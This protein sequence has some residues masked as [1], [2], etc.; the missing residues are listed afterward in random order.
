M[1]DLNLND[2]PK[3]DLMALLTTAYQYL[4]D[5]KKAEDQ[6]ATINRRIHQALQAPIGFQGVFR[7][8]VPV[9]AFV[10]TMVV[11]SSI[12]GPIIGFVVGAVAAYF[13]YGYSSGKKDKILSKEKISKYQQLASKAQSELTVYQESGEFNDSLMFLP[14]ECTNIY[15]VAALYNILLTGRAD[16]WKEAINKYDLEKNNAEIKANQKAMIQN[17]KSQ[18][19]AAEAS[20]IL[21]NNVQTSIAAQTG[22]IMAQMAQID[23]MNRSINS[24]GQSVSSIA[25]N[26]SNIRNRK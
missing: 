3:N 15:A 11:I 17:Q 14:R 24:V 20:N 1:N 12:L 16:T 8:G 21:L 2:L 23:N 6:I 10:I 7:W 26:I 18:I 22:V 13:A 9:G 25:N 5:E 19:Q 4:S